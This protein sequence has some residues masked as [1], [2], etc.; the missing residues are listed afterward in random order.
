DRRGNPG[1]RSRTRRVK[2]QP[3][4]A[5]LRRSKPELSREDVVMA[6]K[7]TSIDPE[8][9]KKTAEHVFDLLGGA[10]VSAMVY[11]GDRMGLYA[12]LNGAGPLTSEEFA[13]KTGLHERWIREWLHGQATAGLIEYVGESRFALSPE[14]GMVLADENSPMFLAGGFCA[15]PQQM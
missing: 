10:Y 3:R 1:P 5:S 4:L 15:L 11:L 2:N 13:R 12:A 7:N 8:K 9:V 14:V 6:A